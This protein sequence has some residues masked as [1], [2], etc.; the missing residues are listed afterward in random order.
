MSTPNDDMDALDSLLAE[1]LGEA[2]LNDNASSPETE[3]IPASA[4]PIA[5]K[6]GKME[7]VWSNVIERAT[8][9]M[10]ESARMSQQV[11]QKNIELAKQ[12]NAGIKE[13]SEASSG[14]RNVAR[15]TYEEI[16]TA[17]KSVRNMSIFVLLSVL[18]GTTMTAIFTWYQGKSAQQGNHQLQVTIEEYYDAM[19]KDLSAKLNDMVGLIE[20]IPV[21]GESRKALNQNEANTPVDDSAMQGLH[22]ANENMTGQLLEQQDSLQKLEEQ[23]EKLL[24]LMAQQQAQ[25]AQILARL[26]ASANTPALASVAAPTAAEPTADKSS[27]SNQEMVAGALAQTQKALSQLQSKM[28]AVEQQLQQS[29]RHATETQEQLKKQTQLIQTVPTQLDDKLAK[30]EQAVSGLKQD[31]QQWQSNAKPDPNSNKLVTEQL[32][33]LQ[34]ELADIKQMQQSL[35]ANKTQGTA[36]QDREL[37]D[38]VIRLQ[39]EI[40][41]IKQQTSSKDQ[42]VK[43]TSP[44]GAQP[45][46]Y[47]LDVER[48][49]R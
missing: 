23:V 20:Q 39:R 28:T 13:L 3:A 44:S 17:K 41:E 15:Q 2:P 22:E 8:A 18:V 4:S 43:T 7:D 45:Y 12:Q 34:K 30:L 10:Q 1:T 31:I 42:E 29:D 24:Q 49:P 36:T 21:G 19:S 11:T 37:N 9:N 27:S 46:Q 32:S 35:K 38:Q 5:M 6:D 48:Y 25:Q 26:E 14:W 40:R 33:K 16:M 47:R